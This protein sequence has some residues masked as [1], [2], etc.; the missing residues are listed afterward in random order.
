MF[1]SSCICLL[2]KFCFS[3]IE[4][5]DNINVKYMIPKY[6]EI[7]LDYSRVYQNIIG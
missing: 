5:F 7:F 6:H 3:F 2:L 1:S 4:Y